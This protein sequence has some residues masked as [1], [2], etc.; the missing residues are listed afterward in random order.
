M[1]CFGAASKMR[2]LKFLTR[3]VRFSGFLDRYFMSRTMDE[4][5]R[6]AITEKKLLVFDYD[7]YHRTVEPHIYGRK[8]DRN[9]MLV[10]QLRG[11][12]STGELGWKRMYMNK[13]ANMKVLDEM[14]RGKREVPGMHS[15]WDFHYFFVDR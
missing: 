8:N 12:S 11:Q 13:I 15:S 14:F 9:G 10:Y 2:L 7:D 5:I 3:L 1:F 4:M 6:E